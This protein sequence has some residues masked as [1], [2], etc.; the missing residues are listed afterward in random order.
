MP[1]EIRCETCGKRYRVDERFAG[2]RV[3]C[4]HCEAAIVVDGDV[5]ADSS[6]LSAA[7]SDPQSESF[8]SVA[9]EASESNRSAAAGQSNIDDGD[10]GDQVALS[11][12]FG[13]A[14]RMARSREGVRRFRLLA[15][16]G[17]A[18]VNAF[19]PWVIGLACLIPVIWQGV[20]IA[21]DS[22]PA[23]VSFTLYGLTLLLFLVAI[24]PATTHGLRVAAQM[25]H[26]QLPQSPGWRTLCV[27]SLPFALAALFYW[28]LDGLS[29]LIFGLAVG[30]LIAGPLLLVVMQLHWVEAVIAWMM[31]GLFFAGSV[32]VTAG[33][34]F[35]V[36]LIITASTAGTSVKPPTKVI[37][38]STIKPAVAQPTTGTIA[39]TQVQDPTLVPNVPPEPNT[40][41][42]VVAPTTQQ[43]DGGF[44]GQFP[45]LPP[46]VAVTP[47][48]PVADTPPA[49][50]IEPPVAV[51]DVKPEHIVVN[52]SPIVKTVRELESLGN[53]ESLLD[54]D[55]AGGA[56]VVLKRTPE[57]D[58][59][60]AV[61]LAKGAAAG[62]VT[63]KRDAQASARYIPTPTGDGIV[64]IATWPRLRAELLPL[65][66]TRATKAMNL[67]EINGVAS[68]MASTPNEVLLIGWQNNG[69]FAV[70]PWSLRTGQALRGFRVPQ[71]IPNG[72]AISGD[73]KTLAVATR[74]DTSVQVMLFDIV[75]G[76]FRKVPIT[77]L[78]PKWPLEPVALTFSPDSSRLAICFEHEGG[79]LI[80]SWT[81]A[82]G[83]NLPDR[84][85]AAGMLPIMD[86]AA[87]TGRA[88][89][90]AGD[91]N[92]WLLYG[93]TLI[94][95]S[96]GAV[97][98]TLG[99][100]H[101][102]GQHVVDAKTLVL[103]S[104]LN[105]GAHRLMRLELDPDAIAKARPAPPK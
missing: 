18:T 86:R 17:V 38:K 103:V 49:P 61:D 67:N 1:L 44:F 2:K 6:S 11:G 84:T 80:E 24:V 70:E 57:A 59:L 39:Q 32:A 34:L 43:D 102:I 65:A 40:G 42:A 14:L 53:F 62:E 95:I 9:G 52:P 54:S 41:P 87:F 4:R 48:P 56:V 50:V 63:F 8:A 66:T 29:G 94:D 100:E 5:D 36:G 96:S 45:G 71:L 91:N 88:L 69:Q 16:P 25:L 13:A 19:L 23:W 92:T 64:R 101:V 82:T 37:A 35:V 97:L 93:Q 51:P 55:I 22:S 77:A 90:W 72:A 60:V 98:G 26:F 7:G 15:Y 74:N 28:Q 76:R 58:Q 89:D 83:K 31:S 20:N 105:S 75:S 68:L 27:Y 46:P 73:G 30:V 3:K 99:I 85:F 79:I 10:K 78:D 104:K 12:G 81:A 33:V 47:K 21:R